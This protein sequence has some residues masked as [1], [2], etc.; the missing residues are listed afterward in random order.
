ML[1]MVFGAGAW[2][3]LPEGN[4][5]KVVL[6]SVFSKLDMLRDVIHRYHQ[7]KIYFTHIIML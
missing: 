6:F 4:M 7:N 5:D 1:S 2:V 3:D